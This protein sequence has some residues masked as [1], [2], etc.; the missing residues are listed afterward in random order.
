MFSCEAKEKG[1]RRRRAIGRTNEG[2]RDGI[3]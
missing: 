3:V 2:D 1:R